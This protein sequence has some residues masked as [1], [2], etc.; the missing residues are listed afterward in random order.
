M[1]KIFA[2]CIML[3]CTTIFSQTTIYVNQSVLGGLQNGTSWADAFPDLQQALAVATNCDTIWVAAGTYY[4]TATT[5]RSI[6]FVLKNGVK[7]YGGFLGWETNLTQQDFEQNK[8]ILSGN[9]GLPQGSDNSYHVLYG[10]GL[11][12]TTVLDGFVVTKGNANNPDNDQNH[13]G[14]LLLN[15]SFD[16]YNTCPIIQNCRFEQ[17]Y[18]SVGGAIAI[19]RWS[20]AQNY[21]NPIIRN[22]QFTSNRSSIF[23]GAVAKVGPSVPGHPFVLDNCVFSKNAVLGGDGGGLF[24]SKTENTTIL[25]H[26]LFEKDTAKVSLGGGIYFASGYEELTGATLIIDSCIFKENSATEGG[27]LY[28]YDGGLASF[29]VPPF[30]AE[31]LSCIFEK[32]VSTNG[33]GAGYAFIGVAKSKL[34]VNV[35]GCEF[36]E[37]LSQS[38]CITYLQGLKESDCKLSIKNCKYLKNRRLG[39]STLGSFP[40]LFG[41]GSNSGKLNATIENCIFMENA[42]GISSVCSSGGGKVIT[43]ITNCTFFDNYGLILNKSYYPNFNGVDDYVETYVNNCIIWEPEADLWTMFSDNDFMIQKLEG[44]HVDNCLLSLD[45]SS[46]SFYPIF[47]SNNISETDPLFENAANGDFRLEACSPAVNAGNNLIV[48]TLGIFTDLDGNPRIRFDTVDIGA[49][50]TQDSCFSISSKEPSQVSIS[51]TV[52]PNPA[53]PGSF[54]DI[55]VLG[56]EQDEIEWVMRDAYGRTVSSGSASLG[57]KQGFSVVAP[58]SPGTY[59]LDMRSGSQIFNLKFVVLK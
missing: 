38:Y 25:R 11:D 1:R 22:C 43:Q 39:S 17:N 15:P 51:A 18:A 26:C 56:F 13:G 34:S 48:D 33:V 42:G 46:T 31:L 8:T 52:V 4:P 28:Y 36:N 27:G 30:K 45:S 20:F 35:S 57:E 32:N 7:M 40:I 29:G 49:Y 24:I 2:I 21:V 44:Y 14:G 12:S 47:G 19:Y 55:Q 23:G 41:L 6:Y 5:D 3:Q 58:I 16:V 10:E 50:E 9:I 59:I 54:L 53:R 37:N